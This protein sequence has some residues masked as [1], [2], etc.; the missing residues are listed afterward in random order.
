MDI[1]KVNWVGVVSL[2]KD[3]V[4][5][6][7][8]CLGGYIA[9]Q[10]LSTWRRQL[11]GNAEYDLA[12]RV[13]KTTYRVRYEIEATRTPGMSGGETSHA[14]QQAGLNFEGVSEQQAIHLLTRA[15]YAVRW[16]RV[17][18]ALRDLRIEMCEAEALWGTDAA[19]ALKPLLAVA[20]KLWAAIEVDLQ[21]RERGYHEAHGDR[22]DRLKI[23]ANIS[24]SPEHDEYG[25][26]LLAAIANIEA[27]ARPHLRT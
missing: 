17:H 16:N 25:R 9:W 13:L 14:A 11:R 1:G 6:L 23:I 4:L 22:M 5:T 27:I 21:L 20:Q 10:G 15:G 3:V 19:E 18:E 26:Q 12:R 7:G 24:D 8:A 2:T